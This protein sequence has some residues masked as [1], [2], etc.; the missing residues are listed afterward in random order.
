MHLNCTTASSTSGAITVYSAPVITVQPSSANQ[1]VCVNTPALSVEANAG[2]GTISYQWYSNTSASNTGGTIIPGATS[3][4]YTPSSAEVGTK[5][6]YC[7]ISNSNGCSV[8][9]QASGQLKIYPI[10]AAVITGTNVTCEETTIGLNAGDAGTGAVYT[11]TTPA[12]GN[13]NGPVLSIANALPSYSG[14]Y[15]LNVVKDGC[16]NNA[17]KVVTVTPLPL[18]VINGQTN[19]CEGSI[20]QLTASDAGAGSVYT[21]LTP[22][23]GVVTNR[24]LKLFSTPLTAV[25]SYQLT[26][27]KD[28]CQKS[29]ITNVSVRPL[30]QASITGADAICEK[31]TLVL[32]ASSQTNGT[33]FEW[34]GPSGYT[35]SG[36]VVNIA[37]APTTSTGAFIL[38]A[39]N[40]GCTR[41]VQKDVLVKPLPITAIQGKA[42][43]C[44]GNNITLDAADAGATALYQWSAQQQVLSTNKQLVIP[45]ASLNTAG[46][47]KLTVT[48]AGCADETNKKLAVSQ[49]PKVQIN[50]VAPV[51]QYYSPLT[52]TANEST[53]LPG[54]G[55]FTGSMISSNGTINPTKPGDY[56]I[57]YTYTSDN[58]CPASA[59]QTVKILPGVLVSAGT[60]KIQLGNEGTKLTTSITGPY[61]SILWTNITGIDATNPAPFV[62]PLSTTNYVVTV[63]N[64]VGCL[65]ADTVT[66]KV[67]NLRIPNAFSPNGDGIHDQWTIEVLADF[68]NC[69]V[70]IFDRWGQRMFYSKGY[71]QP[72]DGT[73]KGQPAATGTYYY[74]I[75]L[76]DKPRKPYAGWLQLLR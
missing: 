56:V 25:G 10:P 64:D 62:N 8:A 49:T 22:S 42:A 26:V 31:E 11:W 75:N 47:Y 61:S 67:V 74:I 38:S 54:T 41:Y 50:P 66:V 27:L 13:I 46:D 60:D 55:V 24:E 34:T 15:N 21:W 52:V 14:I 2:S 51:C 23:G 16:A 33:S 53:G 9:T 76:N 73:V 48:L 20:L 36:A 44:E 71:T 5:Y 65:A 63:K 7:V 69:Q 59:S 72:W 43:W 30:P 1:N 45:N 68:P 57:T 58:G 32:T 40:N 18:T 37:N 39:T 35:S 70:E 3:N 19:V 28:G 6:F 4:I 12:S 17:V 29:A